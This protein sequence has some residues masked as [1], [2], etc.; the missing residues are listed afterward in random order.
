[1]RM[2]KDLFM[3]FIFG[4]VFCG[5]VSYADVYKALPSATADRPLVADS[6]KMSFAPQHKWWGKVWFQHIDQ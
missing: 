2:K 3:L 4:V 5:A 6:E 1:M